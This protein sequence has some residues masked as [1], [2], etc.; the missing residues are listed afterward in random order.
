MKVGIAADHR[1]FDLKE[2]LKS[3]LVSRGHKVIDFGPPELVADDDYPD[4][5][6]PLAKAVAS[7]QIDRG[8]AVC[9]SGVGASVAANKIPGVRAA[10]VL[11]VFSAHQGVEDDDMNVICFGSQV[12][13]FSLAWD[14]T[15]AFLNA[16]FSNEERHSR[17]LAK[18][19]AFEKDR[20]GDLMESLEGPRLNIRSLGRST[21]SVESWK[22]RLALMQTEKPGQRLWAKDATLWKHDAESQTMIRNSLGWLYLP[23]EM[24]KNLPGLMDFAREVRD[25]GFKHVVHMGMGGSSLAASVFARSFLSSGEGLPVTV[26]DTTDAATVRHI[27]EDMPLEKT[28]FI[29]ASKSGTTAETIAHRDYFYSRLE[30]VK[31]DRAGENF[32]AVTDPG[33]PLA[34][35]AEERDYRR[36][37]LNFPDVG[38]RYSA[39][40]Y[41][42]LLPAALRGLDVQCLLTRSIRMA[43]W[44]ASTVPVDEH[45]ALALSG[46]IAE[47]VRQG[48]DKLTLLVPPR[49]GDFGMW[50][51][52]LVAESTGKENR[53]ILPVTGEV[54]I[55]LS[56]YGD[57]RFFIHVDFGDLPDA[58]LK[59]AVTTLIDAGQPV[60]TVEL[61]DVYDIGQEF[62]R[63]EM[64]I[65]AAAAILAINPF[66][67]PDVQDTKDR[68]KRILAEMEKTGKLPEVKPAVRQDSLTIYGVEDA[69]GSQS[70]FRDFFSQ[71]RSG[72][73]L[74][75][76]AYLPE[77]A[78]IESAL[79]SVRLLLR[80]RLQIATTLGYGP[81]YLHSTGQYHKGG[82]NTGLFIQLIA[83]EAGDV[84][85]PGANYGFGAFQRAQAMG[86]FEALRQRGR[87]IVGVQLGGQI[88]RGLSELSQLL[89]AAV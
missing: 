4:F 41:F 7:Q 86:D 29:V 83:D 15:Q 49:L 18:L 72:D 30:R 21:I 13:G 5:V 75:L 28:L 71:V 53:G 12:T 40:S 23:E 60:V 61:N 59:E 44:C 50:V 69:S 76:L 87:R 34:R 35:M 19:A 89:A 42:G 62:F 88:L 45:P 74:G 6:G 2:Q 8:V 70:L 58:E 66:D 77:T 27:E 82:P 54:P 79:Q 56:S 1:G 63:W 80:D 16:R 3:A 78:E 31:G 14:L 25:S 57:D 48:K 39:L 24:E 85:I 22:E 17:R 67:Q 52:Q 47:M 36:L 73:Y 68:T 10:L 51:E 37:F 64:T 33:T 26:V 65:A 43:R 84:R 81:R 32:V 55:G 11:D 38:G 9:G 20:R 46:F